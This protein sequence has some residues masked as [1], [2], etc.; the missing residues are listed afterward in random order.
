M[1][2]LKLWI[3]KALSIE[4]YGFS[5]Y[6]LIIP[7]LYCYEGTSLNMEKQI[8]TFDEYRILIDACKNLESIRFEEAT[9]RGSD[10]THIPAETL[11]KHLCHLKSIT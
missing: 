9:V 3:I 7:N 1:K 10:G 11:L 6:N 2:K 4:A 8:L 5:A